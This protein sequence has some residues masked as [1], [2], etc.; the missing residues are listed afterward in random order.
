MRLLPTIGLLLVLVASG[1]C[2]EDPPDDE[3]DTSGV[4]VLSGG[5]GVFLASSR[6]DAVLPDGW[7][8]EELVLS[9]RASEYSRSGEF[10][11]DGSFDLTP[12][13]TAD[14]A[15]RL[16]VRRPAAEAFN[17]T[18]LVEWLNVSGGLDAA[19]DW[20]YAADEILRGG[21]AWVGVSAQFVGVEGGPVPVGTEQGAAAGAGQGLRAI[22][23]ERYGELHHPGDAFAYDIYTQVAAAV[24]AGDV[25]GPLE[26]ER[27]L[28]VGESQ[29]AFT[30]TT[31]VNG[32]Q[33]LTDAYD[34][35]LLHSRAG[36]PAP[37][38]AFDKGLDVAAILGGDPVRLRTDL[39]VPVLV[40]ETE[41]DVVGVLD[42]LAARQPD[43]DL[44]RVWEVAGSAHA[45]RYQLGVVADSLGC[46]QPPN[47]G[48][49]HVVVKAAVRALDTWV[50]DDV[51]PPSADPL[52]VVDGVYDRDGDGIV[53][54]GIRTP[55]V[56]VPVDVLSGDPAPGGPLICFLSGTTTP[57][58]D[59][60]LRQLYRDRA[61]YLAA[62]EAATDAAVASG[63]VL[64]EDRAALLASAK[65]GRIP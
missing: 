6:P 34:G 44:L 47:D 15:T 45:D 60:R 7:S 24:R 40:L 36:A 33:P 55:P 2:S 39:D 29:S 1:G 61:D 51:A 16:V 52:S 53:R 4:S 30:L 64:P 37:L 43:T 46:P 50:R 57:L 56:D 38:G 22:D 10:E 58:P 8:E 54:G 18:V 20:T 62:Y 19:P 42:F 32:V 13:G 63:F 11:A 35:F 26:P 59:A 49:H 3:T 31:Y 23:P 41:T 28:G 5:K 17:G 9:G 21:Y 25:L 27:V 48:P 12:S 65:P 14:F